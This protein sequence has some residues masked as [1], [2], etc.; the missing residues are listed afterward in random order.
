MFGFWI[1]AVKNSMKRRPARG[2]GSGLGQ[3]YGWQ[4]VIFGRHSVIYSPKLTNYKDVI[5][6]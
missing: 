5:I 6:H 3:E 2:E 4:L 1:L